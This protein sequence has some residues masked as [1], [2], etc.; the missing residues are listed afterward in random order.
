MPLPTFVIAGAQKCG[1]TTLA[2][3]FR[4]HRQILISRPKELHYFNYHHLHHDLDWYADQFPIEPKHKA[5]GEGTPLYLFD[6]EARERMVKALPDAKFIVMLRDPASRAYSH[7]WHNI[8]KGH[9]PDDSFEQA[10]DREP[11]RL[12]HGSAWEQKHLTYMERGK[13]IDQLLALEES[14]GRD[15]IRIHLLED[16]KTDRVETLR[17]L[18]EWLGVRAKRA[19]EIPEQW[20]NK[21]GIEHPGKVYEDRPY[22]PMDPQTRARLVEVFRPYND[23]LGDYLGRDLSYWNRV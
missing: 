23:R 19:E 6:A 11:E 16:L 18:F 4:R 12:A 13:Y 5:W 22:P 20:T 8:N 9:R 1:T 3:T 14:V 10:L 21:A 2:D 7:Y 15:R 17:S